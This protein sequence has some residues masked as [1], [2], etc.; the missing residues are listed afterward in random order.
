MLHLTIW[1]CETSVTGNEKK[2]MSDK[3]RDE[4]QGGGI[5]FREAQIKARLEQHT[6]TSPECVQP[7]ITTSK[8]AMLLLFSP[9]RMH[10]RI[11][12]YG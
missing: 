8:N 5:V 10:Y 2:R 12:R 11:L 4:Q 1:V 3:S 7:I 9:P 6:D